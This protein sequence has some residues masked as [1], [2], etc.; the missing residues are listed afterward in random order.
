[1]RDLRARSSC[2][3]P[4]RRRR[5]IR[6]PTADADPEDQHG[7]GGDR[8]TEPGPQLDDA[9]VPTRRFDPLPHRLTRRGVWGVVRLRGVLET[10]LEL[11]I[12]VLVHHLTHSPA[13]ADSATRNFAR[14]RDSWA[15]DVPVSTPNATPISSCV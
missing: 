2:R 15:F 7:R 13:K 1:M 9:L 11:G 4:V 12:F 6:R 5:L 8:P 10:L 3:G 14:A